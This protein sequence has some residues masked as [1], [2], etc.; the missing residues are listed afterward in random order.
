MRWFFILFFLAQLVHAE[1]L[2]Q[3]RGPNRDGRYPATSLL[4]QW[5]ADGPRVLWTVDGLGKGHTS[6]AVTND[7]VFLTGVHGQ[8]GWLYAYDH[9][10]KL[11]FKKK[12]GREWTRNYSGTRSTPLVVDDLIYIE[13]GQ[14][15]LYCLS[16]GDGSQVWAV[17]LLEKFNS[18]NLPW[19]MTEQLLAD[20]GVL[21]CTPGGPQVGMV[22]L[23]RFSGKSLWTNP[24]N[25]ELSSYCSPIL[26]NHN[27]ICLLITMMQKSVIGV[28][29]ET[30]ELLWRE[31]FEAPYDIHANT[32]IYWNGSVYVQSGEGG[33]GMLL[34]IAPNAQSVQVVWRND[35]MDTLTGH[36]VL[37]D[38]FIYGA[39]FP[40]KGFQAMNWRTGE[41][42]YEFE[43][44][45]RSVTIY[46]DGFLYLY[47]EKGDV[48]LVRPNEKEFDLVS[49][50]RIDFGDGPHWAH[51]V[52]KK[53]R[54]YIRHGNDLHVYDVA[55]GQ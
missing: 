8:D 4:K 23:D 48:A 6:A 54:L 35:N 10:G 21:Y 49:S 9:N 19:G 38:G 18:K 17:N 1:I 31:P 36:A 55:A 37:V 13:S 26:V 12:Y 22:A 46:A 30:G 20:D 47:S 32:P 14:G 5:P 27:G 15:F 40:E 42:N 44:Y 43:Y 11:L 51:P 16:A 24:G 28:A 25:G 45:T 2:S 29:A 7:K 34:R 41:S 52:V 50:F 39:G 3:W 33:D 53:G